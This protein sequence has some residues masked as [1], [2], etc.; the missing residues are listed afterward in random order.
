[1]NRTTQNTERKKKC[2]EKLHFEWKK[3]N[4]Q[5]PK[6]TNG[7]IAFGRSPSIRNSIECCCC[8]MHHRT[9][10]NNNRNLWLEFERFICTA[11]EK[12]MLATTSIIIRRVF[13]FVCLCVH[14]NVL[15][16]IRWICEK[17]CSPSY[18][19][20]I[21]SSIVWQAR[22]SIAHLL[23]ITN[24]WIRKSTSICASERLSKYISVI[25]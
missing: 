5:E 16:Y 25:S 1:M 7:R 9:Q 24:E 19:R 12:T 15:Q 14:I 21:D 11:T 2:N 20:T 3:T 4:K 13:V 22:D 17:L 6:Q 18:S 8:P 23:H 10:N